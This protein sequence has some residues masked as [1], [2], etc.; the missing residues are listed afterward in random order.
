MKRLA[1]GCILAPVLFSGAQAAVI[2]M[3]LEDRDLNFHS[4]DSQTRVAL[5]FVPGQGSLW[6]VPDSFVSFTCW[7][8]TQ[9]PVQVVTTLDPPPNIGGLVRAMD[10][11]VSIG[12]SLNAPAGWYE[13][14]PAYENGQPVPGDRFHV[15]Y[16]G[17]FFPP[18]SEFF[19]EES[20]IGLKFEIDGQVH[21]GWLG[22]EL[23]PGNL[24]WNSRPSSSRITGF[25][26][27]TQPGIP[28][29]A[30][31]VPEPCSP[32]LFAAGAGL[33]FIRRRHRS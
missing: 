1:L 5:D 20:Y 29:I 9:G 2:F 12:A 31:A 21:Y 24:P 32:I 16:E 10:A 33:I 26:Y 17:G 6:L 14:E 19:K 27:E 23:A 25:A 11:G 15:L 7:L 30:G 28:I 4:G 22:V 18:V 8:V 13:G 3:S